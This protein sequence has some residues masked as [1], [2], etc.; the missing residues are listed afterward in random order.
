MSLVS[1]VL[2]CWVKERTFRF[3]KATSRHRKI[4]VVKNAIMLHTQRHIA[5]RIYP[6]TSGCSR[7]VW[8]ELLMNQKE[9]KIFT[10]T[11][12]WN[13]CIIKRITHWKVNNSV[14]ASWFIRNFKLLSITFDKWLLNGEEGKFAILDSEWCFPLFTAMAARFSV[15]YA[16]GCK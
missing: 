3:R 8:S 15:L 2:H 16:P 4:Y 6:I 12:H 7:F 14:F 13:T 10:H 9:K 1:F 11:R 5:S